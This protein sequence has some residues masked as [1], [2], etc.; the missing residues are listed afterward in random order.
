[1]SSRLYGP[2]QSRLARYLEQRERKRPGPIARAAAPTA[3]RVARPGPRGG[4]WRR[5]LV[6]ALPAERDAARRGRARRDGTGRRRRTRS[7]GRCPDRR[8][9]RDCRGA[10]GGGRKLRGCR[11]DGS[12]LHRLRPATLAEARRVLSPAAELRFWERVRSN[13]L[14]LRLLQRSLDALF[15]TRALGGCRTTR[16]TAGTIAASGFE[17]LSLDR[18]F[19]SSSPLTITAAPYIISIARRTKSCAPPGTFEAHSAPDLRRAP[20]A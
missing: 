9:R 17:L 2:D 5:A 4:L 1:M 6:R 16:D 11:L 15:W 10:A 14:P 19:H 18:G 20:S 7:H 12:S 13:R 3:R 8:G